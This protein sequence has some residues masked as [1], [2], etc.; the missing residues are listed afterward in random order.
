MV[1]QMLHYLTA[2]TF[3]PNVR[4]HCKRFC[5]PTELIFLDTFSGSVN[6]GLLQLD[7]CKRNYNQNFSVVALLA[8]CFSLCSSRQLSKEICSLSVVQRT[9]HLFKCLCSPWGLK[10][11]LCTA[12]EEITVQFSLKEYSI[13]A[14][15]LLSDPKQHELVWMME[16]LLHDP[17]TALK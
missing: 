3:G 1:L 14:P 5:P 16:D 4:H 17:I 10:Y 12:G 7:L 9:G 15:K 2:L 6:N 11:V 8:L 13:H